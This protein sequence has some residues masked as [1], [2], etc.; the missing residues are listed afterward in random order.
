MYEQEGQRDDRSEPEQHSNPQISVH[1]FVQ[2]SV[3]GNPELERLAEEVA[4]T[5]S[6]R[7]LTRG[8]TNVAVLIPARRAG[9]KMRTNKAAAEREAA[10][11]ATFGAWKDLVDPEQLKR[12]LAE[13]QS[14]DRPAPH[15]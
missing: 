9:R 10:L 8:A 11:A 4:R 5:Q 7:R 3:T 6:P 15:L 1:V 12:E 2:R 14:D 13:A